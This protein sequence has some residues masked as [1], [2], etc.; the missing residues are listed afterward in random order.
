MSEDARTYELNVNTLLVV[1]AG[2]Y[3]EPWKKVNL[4]VS[5][6]MPY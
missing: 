2:L 3:V 6:A 1:A 4:S 5:M